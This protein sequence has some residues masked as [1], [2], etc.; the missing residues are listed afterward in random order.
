[1]ARKLYSV[2][3]IVA[4]AKAHENGTGIGEICRKLGIS[5]AYYLP[6]EEELRR[7]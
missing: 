6:M 2:E 5:E 1:M 4:A 3:R 7:S